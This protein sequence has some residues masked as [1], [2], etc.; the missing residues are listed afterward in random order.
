MA[1]VIDQAEPVVVLVGHVLRDEFSD[2]QGSCQVLIHDDLVVDAPAKLRDF[3]VYISTPRLRSQ[4]LDRISSEGGTE[5]DLDQL[6]LS[7]RVLEL[8]GGEPAAQLS[9]FSGV[10]LMPMG[11]PARVSEPDGAVVWVGHTPEAT[12]LL[13]ISHVAAVLMWEA[14]DHEDLPATVQRL[15]SSF[16]AE[17]E[18]VTR[19]ALGDLDGLLGNHLARLETVSS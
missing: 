13:P 4:A 2:A 15:Q 16:Q 19:L 9:A 17:S 8:P 3:L 11:Y 10:R 18:R 5:Q 14:E 1:R 12:A 7:G 6:I